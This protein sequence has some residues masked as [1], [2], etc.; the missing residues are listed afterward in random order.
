MEL[1]LRPEQPAP[2]A[3]AVA[4]LLEAPR[5]EPDPWWQ[6]GLDEILERSPEP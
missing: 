2:V 1:E 5:S 4:D 3:E 6:A